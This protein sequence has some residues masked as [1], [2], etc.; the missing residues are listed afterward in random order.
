MAAKFPTVG[1]I[2]KPSLNHKVS[3]SYAKNGIKTSKTDF[4]P[5]TNQRV[6]ATTFDQDGRRTSIIDF[7]PSTDKR[8]S[9]TEYIPKWI[10][11]PYNN[12]S[13]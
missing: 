13:S 11:I 9:T 1:E 2:I 10:N 8:K 12:I 5:S 3:E 6:S 4:H 7:D